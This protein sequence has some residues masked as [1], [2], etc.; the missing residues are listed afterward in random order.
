MVKA[1]VMKLAEA[2]E[3]VVAEPLIGERMPGE[4]VRCKRVAAESVATKCV[5]AKATVT[6]APAAV[7]TAP[8][9]VTASAAMC[10]GAARPYRCAERNRRRERN[11]PRP[12][13]HE[14]LSFLSRSERFVRNP[15]ANLRTCDRRRH[16]MPLT[17]AQWLLSPPAK[18]GGHPHKQTTAAAQITN[19]TVPDTDVRFSK[20]RFV[21]P[22]GATRSWRL[23][24]RT[25]H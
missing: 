12:R 9:A 3:G 20:P 23:D 16:A 15:L 25:R 11:V 7:T 6:T 24:R 13:P 22:S 8:A 2:C 14:S 17:I 5:P 19:A 1:V 10:N 4:C 18:A 21:L